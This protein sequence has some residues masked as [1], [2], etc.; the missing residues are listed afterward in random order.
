MWGLL[1]SIILLFSAGAMLAAIVVSLIYLI[2]ANRIERLTASQQANYL[3]ILASAP[4][5]FG[6]ILIFIAF[7]PSLLTLLGLMHDHCQTHGGYHL[8]LCLSHTPVL[9]TNNY[10]NFISL[11]I[12]VFLAY[13]LLKV[14]ISLFKIHA[15]IKI[16]HLG[17]PHYTADKVCL[18]QSNKP[19]A[20]VAGLLK[21]VIYISDQLKQNL[22]DSQFQAL[23]A[24]ERA[25]LYRKDHWRI[26]LA[27]HCSL[28]LWPSLRNHLLDRLELSSEYSCDSI[29]AATINNPIEVAETLLQV[30]KLQQHIANNKIPAI[31]LNQFLSSNVEKR[32]TALLTGNNKSLALP[33]KFFKLLQTTLV[34]VITI[35]ILS[36]ITVFH[37][38]LESIYSY[39]IVV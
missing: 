22:R 21:P 31:S 12:S 6:I 14:G 34:S 11:V 15:L 29:A 2:F 1:Q 8:H 36:H 25:H 9:S 37:H 5:L 10:V 13:R 20:F 28:F 7:F 4:A 33:N 38:T 18:V 39:L 32:I 30:Y 35:I 3:F 17:Q 16:L 26:F 27:N 23:L 24:H 19:F